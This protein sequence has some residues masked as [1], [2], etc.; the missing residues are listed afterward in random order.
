MPE[1]IPKGLCTHVLYAFA[2]VDSAGTSLPVEWNDEDTQWSQGMY[3]RV[4]QHKKSD[5][6]LKILLSYG[7]Y[8]FGSPIFTV[9]Y[10]SS[11][12]CDAILTIVK[13]LY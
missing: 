2:K 9:S 5:P 6:G 11:M 4:T 7:G 1:D 13:V 8:N 3:S 10:H 12:F